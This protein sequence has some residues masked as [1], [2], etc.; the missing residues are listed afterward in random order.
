VKS[1]Q[2]SESPKTDDPEL[3]YSAQVIADLIGREATLKL[4]KATKNRK[5]YVPVTM[6]AG[7]DVVRCGRTSKEK[8][9]RCTCRGHWIAD[10][11]GDEM[12]VALSKIFGGETLDLAPCYYVHAVERNR[13]IR[14]AWIAGVSAPE[15]MRVHGM[16]RRAI[17]YIVQG[18]SRRH[19][20]P[21]TSE[22]DRYSHKTK[23]L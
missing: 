6:C 22:E 23:H 18:W 3:P 20:R 2:N 10:V 19:D 21:N 1:Y 12:A 4:A 8:R 9:P 14:D 11:V 7:H 17:G 16:S 5:L 15:L 13:E